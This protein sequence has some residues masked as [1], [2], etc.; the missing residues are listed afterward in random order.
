MGQSSGTQ[1]SRSDEIWGC[2]NVGINSFKNEVKPSRNEDY[3]R[4]KIED[5]KPNVFQLHQQHYPPA[6]S[7]SCV[8]ATNCMRHANEGAALN[9]KHTEENTPVNT[10]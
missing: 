5:R 6:L 7:S 1:R 4:K 2:E 9:Y 8:P 3:R 10:S